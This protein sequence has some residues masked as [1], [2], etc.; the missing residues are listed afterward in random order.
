VRRLACDASVTR[1]VLG[2]R[3]EPLDV[4]RR[5]A[6][7]TGALRRALIARDRA[8]RFPGCDRH[9]GWCDAHHVR[10][11]A[12]GGATGLHNLVLLCRRHHRAIHEGGFGLGMEGTHPVFR[13]PDG[14][15]LED[16]APP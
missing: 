7:V 13:R 2:P 4:G 10:H 6:V 11:W 8:C 1:I 15:I 14:S 3:S 9:H 12:D 16:R 5:T